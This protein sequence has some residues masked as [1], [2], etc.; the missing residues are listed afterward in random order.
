MTQTVYET[1]TS[2]LK[3]PV[4]AKLTSQLIENFSESFASEVQKDKNI[5][6]IQGLVSDFL[7]EVK[8]NYVKRMEEED[9]EKIVAETERLHQIVKR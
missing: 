4:G 7:E 6:E 1:L 9:Y 3:D 8:I 5:S 2:T